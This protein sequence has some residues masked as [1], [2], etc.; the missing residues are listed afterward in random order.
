MKMAT[1]RS[2]QGMDTRQ[3][4]AELVKRRAEIAVSAAPAY[5]AADNA[6]AT[7]V[8]AEHCCC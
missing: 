4:L 1:G 6:V 7:F 5:A 8:V 3:E 2:S